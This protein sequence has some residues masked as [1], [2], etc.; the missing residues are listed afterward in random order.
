MRLLSVMVLFTLLDA[1]A[2]ANDIPWFDQA[3]A[4]ELACNKN[5]LTGLYLKKVLRKK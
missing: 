5:S 2:M 4:E 1:P 3:A